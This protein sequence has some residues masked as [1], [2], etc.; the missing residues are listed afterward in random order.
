MR[1]DRP[2]R[3]GVFEEPASAR[4]AVEAAKEAGFTKISVV[5][6]DPRVQESFRRICDV[7][8][9]IDPVHLTPGQVAWRAAL[10]G[11][12]IGLLTGFLAVG[13]FSLFGTPPAILNIAIPPAGAIWGAFIGLMISRGWQSEPENFYDQELEEGEILVA[14][15]DRDPAR[16]AQ[17]ER[18]LREAGVQPVP[19]SEG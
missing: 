19:L 9:C 10:I 2:V 4:R 3:V 13:L 15:E 1:T 18:I 7:K 8:G 6:G 17:A 12:G 11:A 14:I 5:T 16:L